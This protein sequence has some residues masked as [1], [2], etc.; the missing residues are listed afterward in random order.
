[1]AEERR[2]VSNNPKRQDNFR[3]EFFEIPTDISDVL[4]R[5]VS[6]V[7]MPDIQFSDIQIRMKKNR[8]HDK[9]NVDIGDIVI[10]FIDDE[11]G[12]V[13]TQLYLQVL[14]QLNRTPDKY[15]NQPE[16]PQNSY[17]F[18]FRVTQYGLRKQPV[19]TITFR[20]AYIVNMTS[21]DLDMQSQDDRYIQVTIASD[22]M[23]IS[24]DDDTGS[25]VTGASPVFPIL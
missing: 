18:S 14:R 13:E 11:A 25:I 17:K 10:R 12:I 1:M 16:D 6:S 23:D 9:G 2:I 24:F 21:G 8:F 3:V 19:R 22:Y 4:G 5:Q 7:S 15:N 20:N